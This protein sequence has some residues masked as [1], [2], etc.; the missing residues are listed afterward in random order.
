[1]AERVFPVKVGKR[2][3]VIVEKDNGTATINQDGKELFVIEEI[4]GFVQVRIPG[5][6][7]EIPAEV[8][9][10]GQSKRRK[11]AE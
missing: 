1:M 9:G 4:D 10:A 6:T 7:V 3:V 2:T 8:D 11:K 5:D